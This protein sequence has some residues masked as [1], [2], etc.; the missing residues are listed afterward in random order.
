MTVEI[1]VIDQCD[2]G[3]KFAKLP[4]HPIKDGKAR[5]PHCLAI[6]LDRSRLASE[7]Q[8]QAILSFIAEGSDEL[9]IRRIWERAL[10]RG[11]AV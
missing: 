7:A 2:L 10:R 3:H 6:G 8:L 9:L 1:P 11:Q 5:C 4:D